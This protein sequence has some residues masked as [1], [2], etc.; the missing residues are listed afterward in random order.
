MIVIVYI[1]FIYMPRVLG[2]DYQINSPLTFPYT[3]RHSDN[4]IASWRSIET[5]DVI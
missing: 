2:N 4:T 5:A 3:E 1:S